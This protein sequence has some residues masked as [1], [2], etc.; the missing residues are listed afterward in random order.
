MVEHPDY[1]KIAIKQCPNLKILDDLTITDLE[2]QETIEL[3]LEI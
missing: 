3:D 2:R 1:R